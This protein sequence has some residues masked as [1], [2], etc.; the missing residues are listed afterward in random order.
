MLNKLQVKL[1]I[2]KDIKKLT[3]DQV[4]SLKSAKKNRMFF[5]M[6]E[7]DQL[8]FDDMGYGQEKY[9]LDIHDE[10]EYMRL[11]KKLM[12]LEFPRSNKVWYNII[13]RKDYYKHKSFEDIYEIDCEES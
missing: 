2:Q 13:N 12:Q 3:P 4:I 9:V 10:K 8:I 7:G 6:R 1:R 5:V 11:V